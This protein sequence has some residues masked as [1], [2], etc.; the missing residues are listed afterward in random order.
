MVNAAAA[1]PGN[2]AD[3]FAHL[4]KRHPCFS[5]EAH[6]KFGRLH[7]P[8]SPACNIQCRFCK[9]GFNKWE[10]RP[11]VSRNLLTPV[12]A[13][14]IVERALELCPA[15][16]VVGI[17]GPGD[18]LATD[19]ALETLE[20]VHRQFP[21]LIKCLSTNGLM[22]REKA[23][24]IVAA[25]VKTVTVT[26]NALNPRVLQSICSYIFYNGQYMTGEIAARWLILAQLAGIEKIARLGV[27]VKIN[28]VLIPGINDRYI[29]E[30]ARTTAQAGASLINIIPLLPQY[31]M[32]NRR[33]P[34]CSELNTARAAAAKHLPVFRHCQQCRADACGIPGS[35]VDLAAKLYPQ[36]VPTF[37]H[38]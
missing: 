38:G 1:G 26:V 7:L 31:E 2:V 20:L 29:E 23:E 8:V 18:T 28:T 5:G 36:Q 13:V 37:S 11:G 32:E 12:E 17:A 30:V 19:H 27:V 3:Q 35:G 34:D 14:Q 16:T 25:G 4:V 6:G 33:P 22:L 10:K 9:R 15:I 21:H 24:R